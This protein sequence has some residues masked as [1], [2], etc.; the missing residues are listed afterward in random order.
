M[1]AT[2][3]TRVMCEA[4]MVLRCRGRAQ[5]PIRDLEAGFVSIGRTQQLADTLDAIWHR[6]EDGDAIIFIKRTTTAPA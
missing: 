3:Y 2:E 5:V 4:W 6:N 1:T